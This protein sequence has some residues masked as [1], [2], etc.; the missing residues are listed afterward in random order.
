MIVSW[1]KSYL[2]ERAFFGDGVGVCFFASFSYVIFIIL[3]IV[4]IIKVVFS[5]VSAPIGVYDQ[6]IKPAVSSR[7]GKG[8]KFLI[9]CALIALPKA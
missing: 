7:T 1:L 8:V 9:I 5:F 4:N 3:A 2:Y 6:K